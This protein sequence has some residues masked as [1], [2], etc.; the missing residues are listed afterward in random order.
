MV[1]KK[2]NTVIIESSRCQSSTLPYSTWQ[3]SSPSFPG[4]SW[5]KHGVPL[6]SW[7]GFP[8]TQVRSTLRRAGE[9]P[10]FSLFGAHLQK[11]FLWDFAA[12]ELESKL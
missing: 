6:P 8:L 4:L 9:A 11:G 3:I 12:T 10:I 2:K 7:T 1:G 5:V